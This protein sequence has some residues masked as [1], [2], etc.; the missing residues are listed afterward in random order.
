MRHFQCL[1]DH[2]PQPVDRLRQIHMKRGH[3]L[4]TLT[5]GGG[6]SL[7]RTGTH[8]TDGEDSAAAGLERQSAV[9]GKG[10]GAHKTLSIHSDVIFGEP[11]RA[12]LGADE[13]K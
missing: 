5:D 4:R 13:Q 6:Y 9:A 11:R 2:Y 7:G 12:R 8:V 3:W 1:T 10:V